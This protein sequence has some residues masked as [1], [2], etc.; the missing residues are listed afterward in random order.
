[1]A[2]KLLLAVC[3]STALAQVYLAGNYSYPPTTVNAGAGSFFSQTT[4]KLYEV[5]W[6][7]GTIN[8]IDLSYK[9][10][11]SWNC[12]VNVPSGYSFEPAGCAVNQGINGGVYFDN[13]AGTVRP[14]AS[15]FFAFLG[16]MSPTAFAALDSSNL[17]Q[18]SYTYHLTGI[19]LASLPLNAVFAV[20]NSAPQAANPYAYVKVQI[21]SVSLTGNIPTTFGFWATSLNV[22]PLKTTIGSGY[23]SPKDIALTPD[24]NFAYVTE[25]GTGCIL[26]VPLTGA[27]A[28][29]AQATVVAS[30][31]TQPQQIAF[32][33]TN[34]RIFTVEY[35]AAG[36]GRLLQIDLG[37]GVVTTLMSGFTF[38]VGVLAN[39]DFSML[40]ISDQG[41]N[42][43][44]QVALR[45]LLATSSM[46]SAANCDN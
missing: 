43:V 27:T 33:H 24:G 17:Q 21:T 3:G 46:T 11:A 9:T 4:N 29:R 19:P 26:R 28:N 32:D 30:G 23:F 42:S 25:D 22:Y 44:T 16:I 7:D 20:Y 41:T 13:S 34:N 15:N 40:Y 39:C 12:F 6:N 35:A 18:L 45:G 1:M 31:L 36:A 37:S 8:T 10:N 5:E 2:L 14:I 38:A